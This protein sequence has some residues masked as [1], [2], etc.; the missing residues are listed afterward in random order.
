MCSTET[1]AGFITFASN[2]ARSHG[3]EEKDKQDIMP[4]QSGQPHHTSPP[5]R[6]ARGGQ[7]EVLGL[8]WAGPVQRV[9]GISLS[10]SHFRSLSSSISAV[11]FQKCPGGGVTCIPWTAQGVVQVFT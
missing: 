4:H 5:C 2:L 11:Q 9:P 6:L 1:F 7:N 3:P 8:D 10:S